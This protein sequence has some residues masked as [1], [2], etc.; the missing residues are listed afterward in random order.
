M[1]GVRVAA[2]VS[3]TYGEHERPR[4]RRVLLRRRW[5]PAGQVIDTSEYSQNSHGDRGT[6][7]WVPVFMAIFLGS[8]DGSH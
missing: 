3:D 4:L 1:Q 2:Q 8:G 7:V 5:Q 6:W